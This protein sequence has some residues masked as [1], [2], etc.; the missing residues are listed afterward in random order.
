[1]DNLLSYC[2]LVDVRI[3]TSE[4]DLPVPKVTQLVYIVVFSFYFLAKALKNC[5]ATKKPAM[6]CHLI[7]IGK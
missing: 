7:S 2:G 1:M 3:S 4:K 6:F 5:W